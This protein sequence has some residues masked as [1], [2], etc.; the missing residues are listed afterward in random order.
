VDTGSQFYGVVR[1]LAVD[2]FVEKT[3]LGPSV[4]NVMAERIRQAQGRTSRQAISGYQ[5]LFNLAASTGPA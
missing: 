4:L 1:F 3:L 2:E 5:E